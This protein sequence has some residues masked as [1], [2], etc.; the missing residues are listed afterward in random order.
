M[1]KQIF[2]SLF[3]VIATASSAAP[4]EDVVEVARA[5]C[6]I[7]FLERDAVAWQEAAK[8]MIGWGKVEDD[9]L[10]REIDLCLAYGEVIPDADL[11]AAKAAAEQET[12][13]EPKK[14]EQLGTIAQD[15]ELYLRRAKSADANMERLASDIVEDEDFRPEA[16]PERDELEEILV[17]YVRP[18]PASRRDANLT[19]YQALARIDPDN[20]DYQE[21]I[22]RY[23]AAIEAEKAA[24]ERAAR[25]LEKRLIKTTEAFDNSSWSRHPS[26]P[27]YQDIRDYITLYL[28]NDGKG[29]KSLELFVNYT[30]RDGWLFVENA[31]LNVDG[32]TSRLPVSRWFRDNDTEIWEYGSVR[33]SQAIEI[34]RKIA[35]SDRTVVRFNG[36]QFYDDFVVSNTDKKVMREMLALWDVI[37]K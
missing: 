17:T 5:S 21:R 37:G 2:T 16:R 23:V 15:L 8:T 9:D 1:N 24:L 11:A 27:R 34:A 22:A 29:R 26:S 25:G 13:P 36:Q 18:L 20:K 3:C 7:A 35:N 12:P 6:S 4:T 14:P 31:Q 10:K 28:I 30:S 33:G 19:A 32:S